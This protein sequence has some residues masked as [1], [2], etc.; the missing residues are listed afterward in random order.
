MKQLLILSLLIVSGSLYAQETEK[1][2]ARQNHIISLLDELGKKYKMGSEY[3]DKFDDEWIIV[4]KEGSEYNPHYIINPANYPKGYYSNYLEIWL[5]YD[6]Y[7]DDIVEIREQIDIA[8]L[9]A[10][11]NIAKAYVEEDIH[12]NNKLHIRYE[13]FV[14]DYSEIEADQ[15]SHI[16]FS[17]DMARLTLLNP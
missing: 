12:F 8:N 10:L 5:Y 11:N 17:L 16:F 2:I 6:V 14:S 7:F 13:W 9:I 1:T 4:L 3:E 15:L